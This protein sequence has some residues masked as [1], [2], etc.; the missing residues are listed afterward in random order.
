MSQ[1]KTLSRRQVLKATLGVAGGVV[2]SSF[3][4]N[5]LLANQIL[6][7]CR[8][9]PAQTEGP[10]YPTSDQMQ[11]QLDQDN[12]LIEMQG[13]STRAQGQVVYIM[14]TISD[15]R[16]TPLDGAV[17]E[18]WQACSSGK[19]NHPGD[20]DNPAPL[21]PHFQYW[22]RDLTDAQGR[23]LFK[24]IVPGSY[25]AAPGW[26]RPPHIHVKVQKRGF[27][28]LTTQMYFKGNVY[29]DSD[30]ILNAIPVADRA[31][32]I[33]EL[34]EAGPEMEPQSKVCEFNLTL[35]SP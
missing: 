23:Y 14:G 34:N 26:I 32:V 25:P 7:A 1:I 20:T 11:S 19:Y 24:T 2:S 6:A 13:S 33:I 28:E 16:C 4:G 12:N 35:R 18:I 3:L 30:H 15:T 29:N 8:K 27:Y 22:G 5:K 17:I 10:F 9:T 31:A 21:D